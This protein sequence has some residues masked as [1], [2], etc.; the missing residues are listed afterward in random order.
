MLKKIDDT[1]HRVRLAAFQRG[2]IVALWS[3]FEILSFNVRR[4]STLLSKDQAFLSYRA[5]LSIAI[6]LASRLTGDSK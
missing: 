5:P 4:N 1:V 2:E 3:L 6:S